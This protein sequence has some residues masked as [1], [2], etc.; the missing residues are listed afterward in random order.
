MFIASEKNLSKSWN[1][2]N[3]TLNLSEIYST[4][5]AF[6]ISIFP[7]VGLIAS[8]LFFSCNSHKEEVVQNQ[9]MASVQESPAVPQAP[10]FSSD[11]LEV[12]TYEVKDTTSGKSLGWGYDLYVDGHLTIHQPIL[13]GVAGNISFDSEQA[14]KITGT[15]ALD[16]MKKSGGLPTITVQELDSL[17]VIIIKKHS[18]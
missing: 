7:H 16:K 6:K 2:N 14:A 18:Y 1:N 15:F 13:P 17:G 3:F 11:N 10:T 9:E 4:S 8:L 5:M 12:K